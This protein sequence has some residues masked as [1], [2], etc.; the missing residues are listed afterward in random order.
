[1]SGRNLTNGGGFTHRNLT[2]IAVNQLSD[3]SAD[4]PIVYNS[5]F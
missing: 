3:I 4:L 2:N 5:D 1:M